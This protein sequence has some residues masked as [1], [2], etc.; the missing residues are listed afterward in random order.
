MFHLEF[1]AGKIEDPIYR[2]VSEHD[3]NLSLHEFFCKFFQVH[4]MRF[5][6]V[7]L[8]T[9]W[10]GRYK[11]STGR[12]KKKMDRAKKLTRKQFSILTISGSQK[13][14]SPLHRSCSFDIFPHPPR[15]S[16]TNPSSFIS[17]KMAAPND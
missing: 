3:D 12:A 13:P 16:N 9:T 11:W 5:F 6:V 15:L 14:I 1:V 4:G 7:A 17:E 2:I 10:Q 8:N